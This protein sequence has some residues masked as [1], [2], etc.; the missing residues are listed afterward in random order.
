MAILFVNSFIYLDQRR[1][2]KSRGC[3]LNVLNK[4]E[5]SFSCGIC[6]AWAGSDPPPVGPGPQI[7]GSDPR[8][9]GSDPQMCG[10]DPRIRGS[11]PQICGSDPRMRGSDPRIRGFDPQTCD[12]GTR[13]AGWGPTRSDS[14]QPQAP[15]LRF[16]CYSVYR[17]IFR[18]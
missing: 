7:C 12:F 11:D 18:L 10:S 1:I 3:Q 2:F 8:M 15:R 6:E 4:T 14:G 13:L 17:K 16:F 5:I 9:R